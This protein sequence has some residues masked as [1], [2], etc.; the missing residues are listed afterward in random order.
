[1]HEA[2]GS[3][4]VLEAELVFLGGVRVR[5]APYAH[6]GERA[7]LRKDLAHLGRSDARV[8]EAHEQLCL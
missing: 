3:H 2:D 7:V 8:K 6:K 1:M 5:R 4:V